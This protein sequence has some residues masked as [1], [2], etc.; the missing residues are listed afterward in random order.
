[1][2]SDDETGDLPAA[3]EDIVSTGA[4]AD[5]GDGEDRLKGLPRLLRYAVL[6]TN[7]AQHVAERLIA[8]IH[9]LCPHLPQSAAWALE[10]TFDT[11]VEL[12]AEL[13]QR[14]V[15]QDEPNLRSLADCVRLLSLPAPRNSRQLEELPVFRGTR[16][17]PGPVFATLADRLAGEIV[18]LGYPQLSPDEIKMALQ[19]ACSLLER[20]A[21]LMS[22]S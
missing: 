9:E 16:V 8:E 7:G 11:G 15:M 2:S 14:A 22:R 17:P 3:L 13:D 19:Q 18:C 21:P 5:A 4:A 12:A 6:S 20:D 10:R 1:M